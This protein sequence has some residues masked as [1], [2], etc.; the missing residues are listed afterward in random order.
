MFEL[1]IAF[2]YL[3]PRKKHLSSSL[4]SLL[5]IFVLSLVVWLI[6]VFLSITDGI[7]NNWKTKLTT[8]HSAIRITPTDAYFSSYYYQIDALSHESQYRHKT[9]REKISSLKTDPYDENYDKELPL[10]IKAEKKTKDLAKEL[11]AILERLENT[12]KITYQDFELSGAMLRLQMIRKKPKEQTTQ[13]Y[14]TQAS[15]LSSFPE[16]NPFLD[17]LIVP[18]RTDE[19]T[20]LFSQ[21]QINDIL[22]TVAIKS[23]KPKYDGW[24]IPISMI[25]EGVSLPA[26]VSIS[27]LSYV[28]LTENEE[29]FP[30]FQKGAIKKTP[31]GIYFT[32]KNK[33]SYLI[34]KP[35]FLEKS[36]LLHVVKTEVPP[37][38]KTLKDLF[39]TIEIPFKNYLLQGKVSGDGLEVVEGR[40]CKPSVV[41]AQK[42]GVFLAKSF[43]DQGVQI[44][45]R[46]YL[47]YSSLSMSAAQEQRLPIFVAGFYD[48][49]PLFS[50]YKSILV[51]PHITQTINASNASFHLN[52]TESNGVLIWVDHL[53]DT[54]SIKKELEKL[55]EKEG[56]AAYWKVTPFTEYDFAKDMLQQFVSDRYL[57]TLVG[58]IILM[59]ACCNII[60]QL[61]ILVDNK[62]KEIGILL[63]MGASKKSILFIFGFCGM[64]MGF[65]SSCIGIAAGLFTLKHLDFVISIL[66]LLQGQALLNPIFFGQ[67]IPSN[68]SSQAIQFV[69][70]V[71]PILSLFAA[72]VPAIKTCYL[73]VSAILRS[74]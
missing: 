35:I 19:L 21:S 66:S 24:E 63:A 49:G 41:L 58:I 67:I 60:S 31:R 14:L 64:I 10:H 9:I 30:D 65:M 70:I 54:D 59:V 50:G 11:Y 2:K 69:F 6:V 29:A 12:H 47:S 3:I 15:Y 27:N 8:V 74:E 22:H 44:A 38:A 55:L 56:I 46:G 20:H 34:D 32:E 72:L 28:L 39:F 17:T 52:K 36:Y 4:I 5:S 23:L 61:V 37:Q 73:N 68:F 26:Q 51:P 13:S 42:T 18:L 57:F 1:K 43:Q 45:D 40:W 62:K 71:T 16:K 48:P 7:E 25:P 53:T 33:S